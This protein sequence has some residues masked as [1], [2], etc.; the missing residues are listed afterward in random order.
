MKEFKSDIKSCFY[1]PIL[2]GVVFTFLFFVNV[3]SL[4]ILLISLIFCLAISVLILFGDNSVFI[5]KQSIKFLKS[6]FLFKKTSL[7]LKSET[8]SISFIPNLFE[9]ENLLP[10]QK[11]SI[12]NTILNIILFYLFFPII[13]I[14]QFILPN[15]IQII[16]IEH[17]DGS[18]NSFLC[19]GIEEDY[20]T[21]SDEDTFENLIKLIH[22]YEYPIK[23]SPKIKDIIFILNESSKSQQSNK[24]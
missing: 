22:I 3:I 2:I 5:D 21:N 7:F 4:T 13:L 9:I 23:M 17:N 1:Y 6:N 16:K 14:T 12:K 24:S 11:S 18:K 10:F 15:F 20:Y 19:C 8:K